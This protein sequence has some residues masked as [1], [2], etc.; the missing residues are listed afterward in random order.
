VEFQ[1]VVSTT[2]RL[3]PLSE[4][5]DGATVRLG[6]AAAPAVPRVIGV[7]ARAP[8]S[9]NGWIGLRRSQASVLTSVDR[10]PLLSGLLGLALLVGG[11]ALLWY[12]EGR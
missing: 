9:G 5:S 1:E 4:A 12:R 7:A 10:L 6:P 8:A 2:E 11:F 3:A